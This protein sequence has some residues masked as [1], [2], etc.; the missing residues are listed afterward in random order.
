M[1]YY[2]RNKSLFHLHNS[3]FSFP[4]VLTANN[5]SFLPEIFEE[6][7]SDIE[8]LVQQYPNTLQSKISKSEES[9]Q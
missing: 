7:L 4:T 5:K 9:L 3:Q 6:S 8:P 2:V 1:F